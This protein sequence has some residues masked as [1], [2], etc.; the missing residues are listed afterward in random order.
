MLTTDRLVIRAFHRDD[1]AAL[2]AYRSDPVVA[3]Y[4]SWETPLSLKD[5][6][7]AVAEYAADDPDMNGWYQW[8]IDLNGVLIGDIGVNVHDNCM[9]AEIGFT[10]A[11][12]YHR[13]GYGTEAVERIVEHLFA[14]RRLH[15]ISAE[16]DARNVASARLLRKVGFRQEGLLRRN[17]WTK[18]E[19]T[20]DMVFGLL[21]TDPR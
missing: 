9:Q 7:K 18:G 16:C 4:Q 20:D 15:R 13:R 12:Q 21:E 6:A 3:R 2:A 5:A 11:A 10:L 8:A 1:T 17:T 19:W 14:D